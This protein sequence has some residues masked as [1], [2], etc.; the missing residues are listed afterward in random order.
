MAKRK[1]AKR[2]S[3]EE[4]QGEG[5]YVILRRL[6]VRE[7]RERIRL[8][9][10]REAAREKAERIRLENAKEKPSKKIEK[11]TDAEQSLVDEGVDEQYDSS[12]RYF[13]D[14][15]LEWNWADEDENPLPLPKD[16]PA[17]VDGLTNEE[18][19]FLGQSLAGGSEDE[20]K[21]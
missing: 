17:V 16:D 6:T 12:V 21:N 8:D 2:I 19:N 11:L 14:H 10:A 9:G 18:A 15:I 3:S 20:R 4:V 5:S 7:T 1:V 13:A